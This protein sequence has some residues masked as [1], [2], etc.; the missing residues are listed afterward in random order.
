LFKIFLAVGIV[1]IVYY[2]V[3]IEVLSNSKIIVIV[4]KLALLISFSSLFYF[5]KFFNPDEKVKLKQIFGK[6][7][8]GGLSTSSNDSIN[9][10]P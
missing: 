9:S 6:I 4:W 8:N 5:M 7:R 10:N 1:L 3:P 2:F